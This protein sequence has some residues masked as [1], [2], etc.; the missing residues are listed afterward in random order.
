MATTLELINTYGNVGNDDID[1]MQVCLDDQRVGKHQLTLTEMD[2]TTIPQIAA[3]SI[4]EVGGALYKATAAV[5]IS[6]SASSGTNYI[7]L[8]PGT[9]VVTPAWTTTE[10]TWSDAKQGWYGAGGAAGYRY[11]EFKI[12]FSSPNYYKWFEFKK[13]QLMTKFLATLSSNSSTGT[14][15]NPVIFD[16]VI[17]DNNSEYNNSTGIFT[18]KRSGFY[19]IYVNCNITPGGTFTGINLYKN[20]SFFVSPGYEE[21]SG[22]SNQTMVLITDYLYV[23]DE[24]KVEVFTGGA[25]GKIQGSSSSYLSYFNIMQLA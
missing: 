10:P 9:E 7:Y 21:S 3:G 12:E 4:I 2:S 23:D 13:T 14:T 5:D 20:G 8:V 1:N 25:S 24:L 22:T 18:V 17:F 15:F 6:G 19:Q 11:L 16:S